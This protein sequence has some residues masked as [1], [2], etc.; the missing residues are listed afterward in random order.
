MKFPPLP[1]RGLPYNDLDTQ[2]LNLIKQHP[3]ITTRELQQKLSQLPIAND[4]IIR[5]AKK[6]EQQGLIV[7]V[8]HPKHSFRWQYY[9]KNFQLQ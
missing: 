9:D 8:K 5:H 3:G 4:T 7:R 6:L 1:K 2:M